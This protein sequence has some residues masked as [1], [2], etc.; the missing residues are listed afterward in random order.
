MASLTSLIQPSHIKLFADD[1]QI[2]ELLVSSRFVR[3]RFHLYIPE[4]KLL[5][6]ILTNEHVITSFYS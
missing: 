5:L 1:I 2:L 3:T 4:L 6:N